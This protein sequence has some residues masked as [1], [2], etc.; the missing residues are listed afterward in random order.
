[1]PRP[2]A[3]EWKMRA[4]K[5]GSSAMCSGII[6]VGEIRLISSVM[7]ACGSLSANP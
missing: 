2:A 4:A 3:S 5:I 1:M 6:S 7:R